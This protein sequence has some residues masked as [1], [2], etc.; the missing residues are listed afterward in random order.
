MY[1][2]WKNEKQECN[3]RESDSDLMRNIPLQRCEGISHV[4]NNV[5]DIII[6]IIIINIEIARL[7][8]ARPIKK[9]ARIQIHKHLEHNYAKRKQKS[10]R[11]DT[12]KHWL[13]TQINFFT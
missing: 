7:S 5:N 6:V 13:C 3:M 9:P 12:C 1:K 8:S 11:R 2:K 4:T 10:S